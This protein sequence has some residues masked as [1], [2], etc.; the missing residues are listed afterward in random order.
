ME[1]YD[2]LVELFKNLLIF[3]VHEDIPYKFVSGCFIAFDF[4]GSGHAREMFYFHIAWE[5]IWGE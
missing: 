2:Q 5:Y 1:N 3:T 4:Y